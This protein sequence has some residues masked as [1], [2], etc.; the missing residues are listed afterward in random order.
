[1]APEPIPRTPPAPVH[2]PPP[3]WYHDGRAL[4]WWDG[5]AW[6]PFAPPTAPPPATTTSY[7]LPV[8]AHVGFFIASCILALVLRL[9]EGTK[10]DYLRHHSTEALNFQLT[11]LAAWI[12]GFVVTVVVAISSTS[13]DTAG[14]VMLLFFALM[15][16]LFV[17][18]AVLSVM[19]AVRAGRG[20]RWR[21]PV[22]IRFVRG[23]AP[24][25]G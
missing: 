9:T 3:G 17:A 7:V 4:R 24:R 11:F 5:A 20:E 21:Y 1:M 6:G 18:G 16:V 10:D 15:A 19:G 12:G 8:L 23:A 2:G 25:G 13:D 22:S 14:A